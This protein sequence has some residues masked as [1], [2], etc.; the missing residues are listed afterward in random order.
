MSFQLKKNKPA[1]EMVS[2]EFK[3]RRYVHGVKY[4]E[5]EIP[6]NRVDRFIGIK[7]E[8]TAPAKSSKKENKA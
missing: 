6:R 5:N 3:G 1:F 8:Q 7:N 2:G 4:E